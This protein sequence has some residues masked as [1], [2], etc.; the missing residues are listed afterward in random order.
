MSL[1]DW[2]K[3]KLIEVYTASAHEIAELLQICDRDIEKSQVTEIGPDWQ[4]SIAYNA[5]LQASIA[6]LSASGYRARK[7]GAHYRAIQSLA[8]TI[9]A[10]PS[11]V[12]QIDK[13][14]LKRNVSDYERVGVVTERE[15]QQMIIIAKQ[16]R[17]K[18]EEWIR[19]N[20]PDLL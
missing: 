5:A 2:L 15:A 3:D 18:V 10:E 6:A 16:L 7:E 20:H 17:Q 13:F 9:K 4:L 8:F 14:R 11:L 12:R 19:N 1:E